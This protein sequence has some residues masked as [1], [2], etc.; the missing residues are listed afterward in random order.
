MPILSNLMVL[1]ITFSDYFSVPLLR[2]FSRSLQT[3]GVYRE[4]MNWIKVV[5]LLKK[6]IVKKKFSNDARGGYSAPFLFRVTILYRFVL[7]GANSKINVRTVS[8]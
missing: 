8:F 3:V 7:P 4:M 6:Q 1:W 2:R 5:N